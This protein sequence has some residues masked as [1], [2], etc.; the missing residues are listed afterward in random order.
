MKRFKDFYDKHKTGSLMG[1]VLLFSCLGILFS[2]LYGV[3]NSD[4]SRYANL[5]ALDYESKQQDINFINGNLKLSDS[6][7]GNEKFQ[8]NKDLQSKTIFKHLCYNSYLLSSSKTDIIEYPARVHDYSASLDPESSVGS[9]STILL[10]IADTK[11]ATVKTFYDYYYMESIGLPLYYVNE[12]RK[13]I[14]SKKGRIN[15]G[16]YVSSTQAYDIAVGLNLIEEGNYEK[17]KLKEAFDKIISP[18]NNY[19]LYLKSPYR[20]ASFTINNIYINSQKFFFLLSNEQKNTS[21]HTYGHYYKSFGYWNKNTIFTYAPTFFSDN[22]TFCFDIRNS[23][24]NINL[25]M[26]NVVGKDYVK[27]GSS[28]LFRTQTKLLNELS[29]KIDNAYS[30]S[31]KGNMIYLLASILFFEILLYL[32]INLVST[33]NKNRLM[34]FAKLFTPFIPFC[35]LWLVVSFALMSASTLVFCY[36]TFNYLGNTISLIFL[37]VVILSGLL[38]NLFG[39]EDEKII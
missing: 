7:S 29:K 25:F 15:F 3:S 31:N 8:K 10:N 30:L 9:D 37:A 18:D 36:F 16:C 17:S 4:V 14:D 39:E 26:T 38:W 12:N 1:L 32:Q 27:E 11:V 24:N 35:L 5:M 21:D 34:F 23:Y 6:L 20:E 28:I 13:N 2:Y 33:K 19:Y 22:S